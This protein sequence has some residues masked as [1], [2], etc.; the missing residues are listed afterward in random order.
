[1]ILGWSEWGK[2]NMEFRVRRSGI[3]DE[4]RVKVKDR[5]SGDDYYER[6]EE[7]GA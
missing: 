2:K 7:K 5:R 4:L 3:W 1:M 6:N